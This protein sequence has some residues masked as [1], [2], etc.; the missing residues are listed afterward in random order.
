MSPLQIKSKIANAIFSHRSE[1]ADWFQKKFE[2]YP[3]SFYCSVDVRDSGEK[4]APVDCNLFPA[5]FNNICEID[6]GASA[7]IFK[8]Q[9]ERMA[10]LRGI[11]MPE[12]ILVIPENHTENKF[13]LENLYYLKNIFEEAGFEIAFGRYSEDKNT[14]ELTSASEKKIVEVPVV[15]DGAILKTSTGFTPD[16]IILNNDFSQGYPDCLDGVSQP[17]FPT[18]K[19]GWHTRKKSTHFIHY[20]ALA[21]EFAQLIGL[22][23]WHF[24]IESEA[25]DHVNFGEGEGIDR[26]ATV[27]ERFFKKLQAEHD[28]HGIARKPALFIKNDSGTYGIGIMVVESVEEI[29]NMNRRTKNKMSVGKNKT[30]ITQV[31]IQEGVPTTLTTDG[32]TSE[33]VIYMM[34]EELIGGFIRANKERSDMDNLNS[35]GMFFKKLCFKDLSDSLLSGK[36]KDLPTLEAVYGIVAKLSALAAAMEIAQ[37]EMPVKETTS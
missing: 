26:V 34:G 25:V 9:I 19:L 7:P 17:I 8:T 22:E 11:P 14:Y 27:A 20:N 1:V 30:E 6:L 12:K 13:Y 5:G 2:T 18:Y 35:Q 15:R 29:K 4:V 37:V 23:P 24:T 3:A 16:W 21:T 28:A 31:L 36:K 10:Q 32:V 33:P